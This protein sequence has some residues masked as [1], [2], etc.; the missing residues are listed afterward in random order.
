M[1]NAHQD[2]DTTKQ[3]HVSSTIGQHSIGKTELNP[4]FPARPNYTRI[5]VQYPPSGSS[6]TYLMKSGNH[7]LSSTSSVEIS[8][9]K[10]AILSAGTSISLDGKSAGFNTPGQNFTETA[11]LP[12][13]A[14]KALL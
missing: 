8:S 2:K 9:A 4:K 12:L 1:E 11:F 10:P 6:P 7:S 3:V 5:P 13:M 14:L